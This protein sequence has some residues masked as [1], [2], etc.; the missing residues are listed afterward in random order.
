MSCFECQG[1]FHD[2][3]YA[4]RLQVGQRLQQLDVITESLSKQVMEH[5]EEMGMFCT[6][7]I[8]C[9][10]SKFPIIYGDGRVAYAD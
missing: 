8:L 1:V 2:L 6:L 4:Y 3:C 9:C 7:G 5:H 10:L